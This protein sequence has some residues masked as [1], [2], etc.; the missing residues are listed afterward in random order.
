MFF[1]FARLAPGARRAPFS[2]LALWLVGL[3]PVAALASDWHVETDGQVVAISDVHGDFDAMVTTLRAAGIIN[4]QLDWRAGNAQLVI[5][6][7]LLDRGPDS[8][9]VMDLVRA[10][11][12]G[13][14]KQGGAVH[15]LLG[16]HEVMN[17]VG[18]LRYVADEEFAAF[19]ADERPEERERWFQHDQSQDPPAADGDAARA[20]WD[21]RHPPGFFGHR[22][23]FRSD[24]EYGSWLLEKPLIVVINGTAFVHG[25]LSPRVAEL[26][27]DA[28][29]R[30]LKQDLTSYVEQFEILVDAGVLSPAADFY[31][32]PD[33]LAAI[34]A[35]TLDASAAAAVSAIQEL[36]DSELHSADSPLWYRG[37]VGCS[38]V[39]EN[40]RLA[41][42][43][44]AI[45]AERVVVG[46]TPTATRQ[47]L[48]RLDGKVI[49]IDTGMLNAYYGGTGN[50][51]VISGDTIEV[52]GETV[53]ARQGVVAHPRR[54]GARAPDL[55]AEDLEVLLSEGD[56]TP[57]EEDPALGKIVAVRRNG[58]EVQ[59]SFLPDPRR[60]GFAP[61]LAAYRL[62]RYL[63]LN[64]VPATVR[65]ELDGVSGTLQF[66]PGE[67]L[68]EAQR[69]QSGRGGSAWCPLPE[70]WNAM[71]VFD[72]LIHN[73]G[74]AQEHTLYSVDN[75]QLL[76]TGHARSFGTNRGKPRYLEQVELN[77]G[78]YWQDHL[79]ALTEERIAELF[80]G[81]LDRRRQRALARRRDLLLNEAN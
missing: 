23:A 65:R 47:V 14:E 54:V 31:R 37:N 43:F 63:G 81:V 53:A 49:E 38:A 50:A 46:H 32:H 52:V 68:N 62:D 44:D 3:C 26:G 4:E 71:Y 73:P 78:S 34:D 5:T 74:R 22:R 69:R 55:S 35:E 56:V 79:T 9:R 17:L 41:T 19:A 64:A 13:A 11:E 61:E 39:V 27:L 57:I 67:R 2:A 51:L 45:D 66:L 16:N 36:N 10:L 70:Q 72:A 18:D 60:G 58:A 1:I 42:V 28:V 59:A 6:G 25:G 24:G 77:V 40:D 30:T 48:S 8:R 80:D 12:I 76:L 20:A 29:N 75:W 15:L 21:A 7:D 33:L